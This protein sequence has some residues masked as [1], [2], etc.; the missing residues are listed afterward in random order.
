MIR[1]NREYR[2]FKLETRA[3]EENEE[4]SY[5]VRGYAST[6]EP[7]VLFESDG[8]KYSEQIDAKAFDE[9]DMSDVIFLY[10]HEGMVY[11]RQKNGTLKLSVDK[12]GLLTETDLSSTTQSRELFEAIQSDLVDQMSFAFTVREDSYDSKTHT[13]TILK[14]D[15]VY[16]VSAVS[17][18]ANPGTDICVAT[19]SKFDG[20]IEAEKVELLEREKLEARKSELLKKLKGEVE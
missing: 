20:F 19:R 8:V 18:P 16:D 15:K 14:I 7:Y 3:K 9:A 11:A 2:S 1:D 10:N 12:H 4:K 5:V 6:F 17:I 13:R